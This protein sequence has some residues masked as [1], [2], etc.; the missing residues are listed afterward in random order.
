M[1]GTDFIFIADLKVVV[2]IFRPSR[3]LPVRTNGKE[4][5]F[6]KHYNVEC[7]D[8][9]GRVVQDKARALVCT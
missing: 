4:N 3:D 5:R 9:T 8:L 1:V 7:C 6:L 2:L